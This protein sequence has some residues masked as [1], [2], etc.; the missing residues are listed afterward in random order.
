VKWLR[1]RRGRGSCQDSLEA[2]LTMLPKVP[3]G[4]HATHG[5]TTPSSVVLGNPPNA[6]A[7]SA[8]VQP[9]SFHSIVVSGSQATTVVHSSGVPMLQLREGW[10]LWQ[11]L[12][13]A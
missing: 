1:R 4:L 5:T 11:G 3:H 12:P 8:V 7:I 10:A 9:H 2:V 13:S 6:T